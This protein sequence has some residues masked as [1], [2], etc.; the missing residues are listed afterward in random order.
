MRPVILL[1][2]SYSLAPGY[3]FGKLIASDPLEAIPRLPSIP[4]FPETVPISCSGSM[5]QREREKE[6]EQASLSDIPG[7]WES[8][9]TSA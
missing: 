6:R 4:V 8:E 5:L 3:F 7:V 9:H 1:D 2:L